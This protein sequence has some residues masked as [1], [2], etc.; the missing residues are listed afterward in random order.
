MG[1]VVPGRPRHRLRGRLQGVFTVVVTGGP[2]I[3]DMYVGVLATLGMLWLPPLLGGVLIM[4]LVTAVV[5]RSR[6]FRHYDA[7]APSA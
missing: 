2:R 6:T 4:V 7:D 1:R 3:G 5:R